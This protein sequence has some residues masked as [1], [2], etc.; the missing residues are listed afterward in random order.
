MDIT[1]IVLINIPIR[2]A[3]GYHQ[4]GTYKYSY[5]AGS[6]ISPLVLINKK[7]D[8]I[9]HLVGGLLMTSFKTPSLAYVVLSNHTVI[10][11]V[12]HKHF[13]NKSETTFLVSLNVTL[14]RGLRFELSV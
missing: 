3:V 4:N 6:W 2:Q 14:N 13:L 10:F 12:V 7:V 8:G 9:A 1:N 5:K 11:T